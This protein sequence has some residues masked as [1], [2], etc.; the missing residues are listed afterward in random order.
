MNMKTLGNSL[1]LIWTL[2]LLVSCGRGKGDFDASGIFE[3]TE[4]I[5]SAEASG[6]ILKFD[7]TEG[8]GLKEV[9]QVGLI[10]TIPLYLKKE[11]LLASV[12]ATSNRRA[13]IVR[14]IA[15]I[16]EQ[17]TTAQR[18]KKRYEKLL[19]MSAANQKQLD[20]IDS[21]IAVLEKQLAAQVSTLERGNKSIDEEGI[22]LRV[23]V[24]QVDD[25][26][27]KCRITSPIDG[28]VLAKYAERGELAAPGKAL[29]K[30]ADVEHLFLR[31]YVVSTQLAVIAIGQE[32][33]VTAD[34]GD[35]H[36]RQYKGVVT[37]ISDKAEFTP[38]TI[39]T[40]DE[41]ANLVYAVK[42]AVEN[43]GFLKIGMYGEMKFD[44]KQ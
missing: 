33:T 1:L 14:Q 43:D 22:A 8:L 40:V 44:A 34:Y 21:Q 18:E 35:G 12:K 37:W 26:L 30:V 29:F 24:A 19:E 32:V 10:D 23:Q 25:Q 16:G 3:A 4:V 27:R 2:L 13:D 11:Q 42:V 28:I 15:A 38:K 39:Q 20:D 17:I 6:Q 31:A 9:Q 36:N 7:I 41:R 5:V